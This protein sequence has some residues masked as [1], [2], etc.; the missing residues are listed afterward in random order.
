MNAFIR[1]FLFTRWN[2]V[3]NNFVLFCTVRLLKGT[4]PP[5]P[6]GLETYFAV[7]IC[8]EM[9]EKWWAIFFFLR[10][11]LRYVSK[12]SSCIT[13]PLLYVKK[14]LAVFYC[15]KDT[16]LR[17]IG[18]WHG[19]NVAVRTMENFLS[20]IARHTYFVPEGALPKKERR[21]N[22]TTFLVKSDVAFFL[23]M[24]RVN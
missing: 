16:K 13:L 11:Q 19:S 5:S 12:G 14:A 24:T 7:Y 4:Q 2:D 17:V 15:A 18:L 22:K 9:A 1:C 21:T 6:G 20:V 10:F 8:G 23:R 3:G